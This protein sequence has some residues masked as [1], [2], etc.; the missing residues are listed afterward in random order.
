[1]AKVYLTDKEAKALEAINTSLKKDMQGQ[2]GDTLERLQTLQ[3]SV[4]SILQKN[5]TRKTKSY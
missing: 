4:D 3:K 5:E 1:M 2:R